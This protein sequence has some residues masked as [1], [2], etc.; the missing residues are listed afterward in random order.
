VRSESLSSGLAKRSSSSSS[1]RGS[2]TSVLSKTNP[3]SKES[4]SSPK[5]ERSKVYQL[6]AGSNDSKKELSEISVT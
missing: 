1:K 4:T 3:D 2:L 6:S 5:T